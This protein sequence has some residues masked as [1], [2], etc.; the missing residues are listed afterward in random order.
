LSS[1][2]PLVGVLAIQ[3]DFAEHLGVLERLGARTRAVRLPEQLDELDG[4]VIPGGESTTFGKLAVRYGFMQ[5]VRDLVESGR[6]VWGTCAGLIF[7]SR[8]CGRDQPILEVMDVSVRRNA[9]GS[10]VDSFECALDIPALGPETFPGVFIRAPLVTA[11]GDDV[12]VLAAI[13]AGVVAV[14]QA[15]LLGTCFHPELTRDQRM[16]RY[17]LNKIVSQT[18]FPPE[19]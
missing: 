19:N 6:P 18:Q 17:F 1:P 13:D 9:F 12:K 3:G 16:H 15:N 2:A 5:P 7:L 4:L 14:E 11:L 8:D 10:Q